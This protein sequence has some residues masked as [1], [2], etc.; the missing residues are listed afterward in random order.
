VTLCAP[1]TGVDLQVSPVYILLLAEHVLELQVFDQ[2]EGLP[3]LAV[4]LL[5]TGFP[6]TIE[7]LVYAEL[8]QVG[9]D[10][11]ESLGP[12]LQFGDVFEFFL[13]GLRIIPEIRSLGF[14]FF[15]FDA[16]L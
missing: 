12:F 1:G 9:F 15:F 10:L 4:H 6:L 8:L 5:L 11:V 7:V 2:P 3:I 13:G 16:Y 14:L